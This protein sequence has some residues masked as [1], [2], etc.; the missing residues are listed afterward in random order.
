VRA[1]AEAEKATLKK[2]AEEDKRR[3]LEKQRIELT[4]SVEETL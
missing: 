1:Q 4:G 2:Q 3:A